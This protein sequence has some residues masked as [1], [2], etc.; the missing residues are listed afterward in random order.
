[1][2]KT[3]IKSA[4]GRLQSIE[5]DYKTKCQRS[6]FTLKCSN[7]N[8]SHILKQPSSDCRRLAMFSKQIIQ[9]MACRVRKRNLSYLASYTVFY[10][11]HSFGIFFPHRSPGRLQV[12][13]KSVWSLHPQL[14]NFH[15]QR[16][17]WWVYNPSVKIQHDCRTVL[18]WVKASVAPDSPVIIGCW[19][20]AAASAPWFL[21]QLPDATR[22]HRTVMQA[23][24]SL[25]QVWTETNTQ[26]NG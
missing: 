4:F 3:K 22:H 13:G 2:Q 9:S 20:G 17:S 5:I 1:M 25:L 11:T 15:V 19:I 14:W 24:S 18:L 7:N 16:T 6:I 10:T 21:G 26:E 8:E 23:S 12:A